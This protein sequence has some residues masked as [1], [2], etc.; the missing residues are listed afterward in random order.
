MYFSLDA[1]LNKPFILIVFKAFWNISILSPKVYTN[2]LKALI[3]YSR[4]TQPYFKVTNLH[5]LVFNLL[6]TPNNF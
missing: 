6:K 3:K 2:S 4:K 5:L 1:Y